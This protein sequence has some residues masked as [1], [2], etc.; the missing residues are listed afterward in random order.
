M[1][2][3]PPACVAQGWQKPFGPESPAELAGEGFLLLNL[4]SIDWKRWLFLQM[5]RHQCKATRTMKNQ[6]NVIPP[7]EQ[8]KALMT[9]PEEMEIYKLPDDKF[10]IVI[11]RML[12]ELQE[13]TDRQAD[14]IRET[15]HEQNKSNK[16]ENYFKTKQKFCSWR[17]QWMN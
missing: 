3:F 8:N 4:V 16:D 7:K 15:I 12:S 6:G 11:W 5:F 9:S 17:I 10:K 14:K 13:D 1:A 2:S